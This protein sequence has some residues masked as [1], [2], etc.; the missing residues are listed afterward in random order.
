MMVVVLVLD[1]AAGA[2]WGAGGAERLK[3]GRVQRGGTLYPHVN[4]TFLS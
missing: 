3:K 4:V 2:E 1:V